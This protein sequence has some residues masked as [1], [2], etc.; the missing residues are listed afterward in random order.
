MKNL[1]GFSLLLLLPLLL[2]SC[3]KYEDDDY[4]FTL[5]SPEKRIIGFYKLTECSVNGADSIP[6][7]EKRY[8]KDF[9]IEFSKSRL[10]GSSSKIIYI[11][12]QSNQRIGSGSWELKQWSGS[13][14]K[15]RLNF[16]LGDNKIG[17]FYCSNPVV[18]K[19]T[20]KEINLI[21]DETY[22][23]NFYEKLPY[24]DIFMVIKLQCK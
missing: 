7:F 19:L 4:W 14:D 17:Y 24:T 22:K 6:Y 20:N 15:D 1:I 5:K 11:Y 13:N 2:L 23:F 12:N 21:L 8:G 9:I 18:K 10:P 3:K 16:T